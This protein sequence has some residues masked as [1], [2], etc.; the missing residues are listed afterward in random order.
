[1]VSLGSLRDVDKITKVGQKPPQDPENSGAVVVSD[2]D[3]GKPV[4][5]YQNIDEAKEA[6][7]VVYGGAESPQDI[8][9]GS[10][11]SSTLI[12]A[13]TGVTQG[14]ML[15]GLPGAVVGG[16]IGLLGGISSL[17]SAQDE[18]NKAFLNDPNR[19]TTNAL[20]LVTDDMSSDTI[21]YRVNKDLL[22]K[23][24]SLSGEKA[25]EYQSIPTDTPVSWGDD[26]HLKI[27]V[28]N[29]F[30]DSDIYNDLV[31]T[32][33]TDYGALTKEIDEA[34]DG[35]Y[36][37]ELNNYI[38][39]WQS[40][41][42]YNQAAAADYESMY[43]G[44]T[45]KAI[46]VAIDNQR[47]GYAN[48]DEYDA[49]YTLTMVQDNE[50]K[51]VSAQEV[52][53]TI[54]NM[55]G[56]KIAKD[57][58]VG[59]LFATLNDPTV[60]DDYKALTYGVISAIYGASNRQDSKYSGMLTKDFF[61]YVGSNVY[62]LGLSV[63]ELTSTF[64]LGNSYG[65]LQYFQDN[66]VLNT[67]TA[68]GGAATNV[69]TS[70]IGMNLIE[71][72]LRS[73][74]G[75]SKLSAISPQG[76]II[77]SPRQYATSLAFN[78]I[79]DLIYEGLK[80]GA[81]AIGGQDIT[82]ENFT[83][84]YLQ[85]FAMDLIVTGVSTATMRV[86]M[87]N[88]GVVAENT[89]E[90]AKWMSKQAN[91]IVATSPD[92]NTSV[93]VAYTYT[94]DRTTPYAAAVGSTTP[95]DT[96]KVGDF[97][98]S[99]I[100]EGKVVQSA[101]I[102]TNNDATAP[103]KPSIDIVP[104]QDDFG[105][106]TIN[107]EMSN[108]N[109]SVRSA[110]NTQ[111]SKTLQNNKVR[112]AYRALL[113]QNIA[114]KELGFE[115]TGNTGDDIYI[116]KISEASQ[117]MGA[118]INTQA[119]DFFSGK[120]VEHAKVNYDSMLN[121][122][123]AIVG[124][125]KKAAL[126]DDQNNYLI[127]KQNLSRRKQYFGSGSD[128]YRRAE[129]Y[130]APYLNK[131]SGEER[132]KL[133][134]LYDDISKVAGDIVDFQY[135]KELI[136][137]DDL[138]R[139]TKYSDYIP[140][141]AKSDS[142]QV[143]SYANVQWRATTR[144]ERDLE[145]VTPPSDYQSP[146]ISVSQML[147]RTL[148]NAARNYQIKT[149]VDTLDE[150]SDLGVT[151]AVNP[152]NSEPLKEMSYSDI[153]IRYNVPSEIKREINKVAD[154]KSKWKDE[155][156]KI[157]QDNYI[158]KNI[159]EYIDARE[160]IMDSSNKTRVELGVAVLDKD[161]GAYAKGDSID[162]MN[163]TFLNIMANSLEGA[164]ADAAKQMNAKGQ[165]TLEPISAANKTLANIEKIITTE[166]F[167]S[168]KIVS[169]VSSLLRKARPFISKRQLLVNWVK[170]NSD[171]YLEE[172]SRQ[173]AVDLE[174]GEIVKGKPEGYPVSFYAG[175]VKTTIYLQSKDQ[176]HDKLTKEI[177][178]IL[179]QPISFKQKNA[180]AKVFT[181][182]ARLRRG[183][184]TV[185]NPIRAPYNL[186]RDQLRAAVS[187][188]GVYMTGDKWMKL[189]ASVGDNQDILPRVYADI[190]RL[191]AQNNRLSQE[192]IIRSSGED[193]LSSAIVNA[194]TPSPVPYEQRINSSRAKRTKMALQHQFDVFKYNAK[195]IGKGGLGRIATQITDAAE[196]YTRNKAAESAYGAKLVEELGKGTPIDEAM[197][198]AF[199]A[200]AWAGRNNTTS[201]GTKGTFTGMAAQYTPYAYASF[202]SRA[203]QIES[204]AVDPLG[205]SAY[206][207]AFIISYTISLASILSNETSRKNYL[208]LDDYTKSNN[209]L[210]PIDSGAIITIPLDEELAGY[211][212][213]I[214]LLLESLSTQ[215]P[216][217]FWAVVGSFMDLS[218]FDLSGFTEGDKFNL[219]RG[220]QTLASNYL[221]T[222]VTTVG[223]LVTGT[224][225]YYGSSIAVD[226]DY[227][228]SYG[229]IADSAGD[230]TKSG[231][232]SKT[233]HELADVLGIPQW[234][235]QYVVES[236]G[237]DIGQYALYVL[238]K[239]RGATENSGD[240]GGLDPLNAAIKGFTGAD[241]QNI[242]SKFFDGISNLKEQ[243]DKLVLK[244]QSNKEAQTTA[245]GDELTKLQQEHTKMIQDFAVKAADFVNQYLTIYEMSGGLTR[246]QA[247]QIY[248]LFDFSDE[249]GGATFN[250]GTAGDYY[251]DKL[252]TQTYYQRTSLSAPI[253]DRHYDQ[254]YQIYKAAD[255]TFQTSSPFGNQAYRNS[256][257]NQGATHV[258]GLNAII[259]QNDLST[260]LSKVYDER[261]K[262]YAKG[263]L[264]DADYDE[265]DR[266]ALEWDG[267]LATTLLPYMEKNGLSVLD[268]SMVIDLLDGYFIVP[269]EYEKDNR[270]RYISASRLNKNR[271]FAKSYI[272]LVF[273]EL[274]VK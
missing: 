154:T 72:G 96:P 240:L 35:K 174:T 44:A 209:I 189:L 70:I 236:L 173:N 237:G 45:T 10:A 138:A 88:R 222:G 183:T 195:N 199:D 41:Y 244:L 176:S 80:Y 227:L 211:V 15:G 6:Y 251:A 273:S 145:T 175:G 42:L 66:E 115:A 121:S 194:N 148:E 61:D 14:A 151:Y 142:T 215:A 158:T 270:G 243:K 171:E 191:Y 166:Q 170:A 110:V 205:V 168:G 18:M 172:I 124:T 7:K 137:P 242:T 181:Q 150:V 269:G 163:T 162:D 2:A 116:I 219:Q 52:F 141:W 55:G 268:N 271:G 204:F 255:G 241:A 24:N 178:D 79:S 57:T 89:A 67:I 100:K 169:L 111:L 196:N 92:G 225:W 157:D 13:T 76:S 159:Q 34:N 188:G 49:D 28:S 266:I 91:T 58:Y 254:T 213:S 81:K 233:L 108:Y 230:Y 25:K 103:L 63:N 218:S 97:D 53:D 17:Q 32:I 143:P 167:Q 246:Q 192:S 119:N 202:S 264:T 75:I 5:I 90:V 16:S 197:S 9:A 56:D 33:K 98:T 64:T 182:L 128:V 238:D 120:Y 160:Y 261:D 85:D 249:Y 256:V 78:A 139:I 146:L 50:L 206:A 60:N 235:I 114:L 190:D 20:E 224:D 186:A 185:L 258:A 94:N 245:T 217:S 22:S 156:N 201:F 210:I 135:K 207:V 101:N 228:A 113:D 23:G 30:A 125:S 84:D 153:L 155:L 117:E 69:A 93:T 19:T 26:G 231:D 130:Y 109:A 73:I 71:K 133:D 102:G 253:L 43:P 31:D 86:A 234:A 8:S 200:G 87:S 164:L 38:S 51:T 180:I 198:K 36:L 27:K 104:A 267:K 12:P 140:V 62:V 216:T 29:S 165:A 147:N 54:Y 248:Y 37:Q 82:L 184:I 83:S 263:E 123:K 161:M 179:N 106:V 95:V 134:R 252:D 247:M 272:Q 232:N 107:T 193:A 21:K 226:D 126:N 105:P 221:P 74:P 260:E 68:F 48:T 274:G 59:N 77:F 208:N 127:A 212:S 11:I 129:I 223:E 144:L 47:I 1:M 177:A 203:S 4:E 99:N 152:E 250:T 40:Q 65:D 46:E 112:G 3:T 118:L 259:Q 131:V 149:V 257:Y 39:G 132:R 122:A 239:L 220:I 214:R 229:K 136:T 262:I 265:L 187:S